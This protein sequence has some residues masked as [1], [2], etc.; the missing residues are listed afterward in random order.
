MRTLVW[1]L[2][3]LLFFT[4]F[5]FALNNSHEAVVHW[6]FGHEWRAP[7]VIIVLLAFGF[8]AAFGVLAMVPAWWRHRRAAQRAEPLPDAPNPAPESPATPFSAH[9]DGV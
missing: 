8:G 5:A 9:Q 1:L 3:A 7:Q 2:R 6:F 4:L